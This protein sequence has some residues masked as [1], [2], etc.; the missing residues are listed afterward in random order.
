MKKITQFLALI[1]S[2]TLLFNSCN[3]TDEPVDDLPQEE[4]S[5]AI[6]SVTD[7]TT[8]TT[9]TYN[10]QVN[11]SNTPD[12]KL[13]NGRE[14]TVQI[15]L[16]NG[17]EDVT[18]EVIDAKDEHFFTFDFPNSDI[19]LTRLDNASSTRAD[20]NKVG[21]LTKWNVTTAVKSATGAQ[22]RLALYHES[23][24][25]SENSQLSGNGKVYGTQ[26]GGETDLLAP[27]KIS[28]P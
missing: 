16:K 26:S 17:A 1:F 6:L 7:E 8:G 15:A 27:F 5:N 9:A 18:Q 20:G 23:I 22:I 24:S 19:T 3:R 28:N 11:G 13:I 25:L 12:I 14:Y 4:I 21:L 10:Y 2:F